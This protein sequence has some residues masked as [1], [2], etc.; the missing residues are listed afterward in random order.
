MIQLRSE[1]KGD[2]NSE[3]DRIRSPNHSNENCPDH[4]FKSQYEQYHHQ[5]SR[6]RRRQGNGGTVPMRRT[7]LQLEEIVLLELKEDGGREYHAMTIRRLYD[8]VLKSIVTNK[9]A[10]SATA[11]TMITTTNSNERRSNIASDIVLA[12]Q[13]H[14]GTVNNIMIKNKFK[15]ANEE[16]TTRNT[17]QHEEQHE[18]HICR[19]TS[20]Q[21][22]TTKESKHHT[23]N[24]TYRE[25]LGGYIHP[26]D[27][28]RLVTPFTSSNEPELMVRRHVMLLNFDPLR[29][30]VLRNRLLV[31]VPDGADSI[32]IAL[33]KTLRGSIDDFVFGD[34]TTN[35]VEDTH[36]INSLVEMNNDSVTTA[37]RG[38]LSTSTD[39][40]LLDTVEE[41]KTLL[42]KV[43]H[44]DMCPQDITAGDESNKLS[45]NVSDELIEENNKE[46][47]GLNG[48]WQDIEGMDWIEMPFELQSVDAVLSCVCKMLSDDATLLRDKMVR[49]MEALRSD[50]LRAAPGDHLRLL[51][52]EVKEMEARVQGFQRAI[53]QILDEDEDLALMNLSRLITHPERFIQPVSQEIL[54]EES[55]EPEL[56]LEAYMQQALSEANALELLKGNIS[57]TEELVS[58]QM[59]TVRNRL[60]YMNTVVSVI[61][62]CVA[63]ASLIGSIFG[64]NLINHLESDENAF[65]EVVFGT[66]T[67]CVIILILFLVLISN[68][69]IVPS[70]PRKALVA[71]NH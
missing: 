61:S 29:A 59:D 60:L 1:L 42:T 28:R 68:T 6:R 35:E 37:H 34:A 17:A 14:S 30:I 65:F 11:P 25:R 44:N 4:N 33:E 58:L 38:D 12:N 36:E 13:T 8:Y 46:D 45:M 55:D 47:P 54:N 15:Q 5:Y 20:Q 56:I 26:R 23:E 21:K 22:E 7:N 10:N 39:S 49:V 18:E 31:L 50:S 3:A 2:E 70:N 51:K 64:M 53:H 67:V 62:L 9:E 41:S 40:A 19:S 69:G 27:M 43:Q 16:F 24:V 71:K 52:D 66:I 57:N 48:E 63:T 32:L